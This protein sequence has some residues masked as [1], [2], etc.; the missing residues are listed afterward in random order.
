MSVYVSPGQHP[1][2]S[3]SV[4]S[5]HV[6]SVA[7]YNPKRLCSITY[8]VANAVMIQVI[9]HAIMILYFVFILFT[10]IY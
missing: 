5:V 10:V 8:T 4:L 2:S 3:G 9:T 6:Y 1:C 7:S